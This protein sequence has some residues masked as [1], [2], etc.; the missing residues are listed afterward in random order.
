MS[1]KVL[2]K[3]C[4]DILVYISAL[5]LHFSMKHNS[6]LYLETMRFCEIPKVGFY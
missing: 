6:T 5:I 1:A 4:V 3:S 2:T